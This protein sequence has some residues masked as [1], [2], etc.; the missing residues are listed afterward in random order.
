MEQLKKDIYFV[1]KNAAVVKINNIIW[2]T[3]TKEAQYIEYFEQF[4]YNRI[5]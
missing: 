2:R 3:F 5:P 4:P 1:N